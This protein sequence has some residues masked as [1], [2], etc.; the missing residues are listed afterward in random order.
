LENRVGEDEGR[1]DHPHDRRQ[2]DRLNGG[3][4]RL[5][6]GL[7]QRDVPFRAPAPDEAEQQNRL[8]PAL[9]RG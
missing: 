3:R 5:D 6:Q 2:G 7:S 9:E 8:M 4:S 1:A